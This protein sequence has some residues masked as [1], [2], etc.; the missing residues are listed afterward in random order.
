MAEAGEETPGPILTMGREPPHDMAVP[1]SEAHMLCCC[2]TCGGPG[3]P[4]ASVL[5]PMFRSPAFWSSRT[6][7]NSQPPKSQPSMA[8]PAPAS[9]WESVSSSLSAQVPSP[10]SAW[11]Q[12]AAVWVLPLVGLPGEPENWTQQTCCEGMGPLAL[13][14]ACP[15]PHQPLGHVCPRHFLYLP[16]H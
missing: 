8:G 11:V 14:A 6:V 9:V 16:G 5:L 4:R 2:W 12:L 3:G 13:L 10:T 15:A 7:A 1:Q